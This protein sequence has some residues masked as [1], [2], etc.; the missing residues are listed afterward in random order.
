M[1]SPS[2]HIVLIG[3][4]LTIACGGTKESPTGPGP[5]PTANS[6]IRYEAIGAS[7][8]LGVGS[9]VVCILFE[10][11]AGGRGYVQVAA[12]ELRSRGFTVNARPLGIPATVI[13]RR[14]Q[15]LGN[16]YGNQTFG[17][18]IDQQAPFVPADTTLITIFAGANDVNRITS[19]LGGGAGGADQAGYINGQIQAF[20]D[21]FN[22]LVRLV[23]E[24]A[25]Q[26][27]LVV[28]NLPNM[29]GM[30]LLAGAS[31]THR[32]A[33]QMLSVGFTTSAI[34]AIA[35]QG[36]V[37]IDLMCDPRAY[38]AVTYSSDGF[39]PSDTGYA[40]MAAEVVAAATGSYRS[41][42]GSCAQMTIV[43]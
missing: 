34:N 4:A 2:L 7:D 28:L 11:C 31:A 22:T 23:R 14:L 13:S 16:Q 8:T 24:R 5:V 35:G 39:H 3:V 18:F 17:N 25:P 12:R 1:E 15:D 6:A 37:V 10:D 30:P 43:S 26:A 38:Q 21:D 19:A 36:A 33:A 27:R 20:R 40:W 29:A 9:S 32:R 41:P 42:A